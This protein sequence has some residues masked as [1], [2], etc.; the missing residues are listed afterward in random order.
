[1]EFMR[2]WIVNPRVF[3]VNRLEAHSTHGFYK[4][5]E[6]CERGKSGFIRSLNGIWK[7]HYAMNFPR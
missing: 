5:K 7:F 3:A 2:E 4:T 6:E 1:M